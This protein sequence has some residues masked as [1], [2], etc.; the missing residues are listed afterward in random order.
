METFI[1]FDNGGKTF[2]RYTILNKETGDIYASSI[3]PFASDGFTKFLENCAKQEATFYGMG[4][5]EKSPSKKI[6][7]SEV[8]HIIINAKL[9]PEW[10]GEPV[11]F[12]VLPENVRK[13]LDQLNTH[14]ENRH[15]D[16]PP[17]K[18]IS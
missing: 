11:E 8:D 17:L 7:K 1:V 16:F 2:D 15:Q 18:K 3:D 12:A 13:F 6:I 14:D 5:R 9:N 10:I 4:W